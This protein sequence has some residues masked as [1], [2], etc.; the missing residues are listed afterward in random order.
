MSM[1]DDGGMILTGENL[2]TRRKP[3]PSATLSTTNLTWI[4]LGANPGLSG[5]RR[6][7][8]RLSHGTARQGPYKDCRVTEDDDECSTNVIQFGVPYPKCL[9]PKGFWILENLH[10]VHVYNA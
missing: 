1:E 4:Y 10:T 5:E 8:N 7:T 3:Y 2:R 9:G 6:A